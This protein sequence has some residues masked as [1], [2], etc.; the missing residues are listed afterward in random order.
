MPGSPMRLK[1]CEGRNN[2]CLF[3]HSIPSKEE[4]RKYLLKGGKDCFIFVTL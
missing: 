1:L 2:I 3:Y 4:L